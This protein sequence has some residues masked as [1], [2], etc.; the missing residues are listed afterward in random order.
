MRLLVWLNISKRQNWCNGLVY[1]QNMCHSCLQIRGKYSMWCIDGSGNICNIQTGVAVGGLDCMAAVWSPSCVGW[2]LG[3]GWGWWFCY[4]GFV[5]GQPVSKNIAIK[6][7]CSCN[8]EACNKND[9]VSY[10]LP[11]TL[12]QQW[13]CVLCWNWVGVCHLV[14]NKFLSTFSA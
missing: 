13:K 1:S 8:L 14:W 12:E 11:D 5:F 6:V 4:A 2:H 9:F 7:L 3:M 10:I